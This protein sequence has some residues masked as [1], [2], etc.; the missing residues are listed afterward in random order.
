M[1]LELKK[2]SH[3]FFTDYILPLVGCSLLQQTLNSAHLEDTET[4]E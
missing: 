2:F 4:E 1:P 3:P